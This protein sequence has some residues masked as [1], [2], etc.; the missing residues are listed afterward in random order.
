MLTDHQILIV[1]F[2]DVPVLGVSSSLAI[3]N[4]ILEDLAKGLPVYIVG[5]E[6]DVK[7]RLKKLGLLDAVS[8]DH[9]LATRQEALERA[10][11]DLDTLR[12]E[13]GDQTP[14]PA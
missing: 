12:A 14:S 3:E 10:N 5:A 6:G 9:V 1:D 13:Q 8:Q 2:T 7:D 4:M 11:V